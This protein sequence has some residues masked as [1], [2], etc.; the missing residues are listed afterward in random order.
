MR[1]VSAFLVFLLL[2][3]LAAAQPAAQPLRVSREF[4]AAEP[5]MGPSVLSAHTAVAGA[6]PSGFLVAWSQEDRVVATLVGP[7]G[8]PSDRT[9]DLG[10]TGAPREIVWDGT[11]WVVVAALWEPTSVGLLRLSEEGVPDP[12]GW[13]TLTTAAYRASCTAGSE[14]LL[15]TGTFGASDWRVS[16]IDAHGDELAAR[17]LGIDALPVGIGSD[18]ER[19]MVVSFF[20]GS[21]GLPRGYGTT[22]YD[23]ALEPAAGAVSILPD[24]SGTGDGAIV[25]PSGHSSWLILTE[26]LLAPTAIVVGDDGSP[27]MAPV[28][29]GRL[30][31]PRAAAWTGS[32]WLVLEARYDVENVQWAPIRIDATGSI[33]DAVTLGDPEKA[34]LPYAELVVGA[35]GIL[36]VLEN[37]GVPSA[38]MLDPSGAVRTGRAVLASSGRLVGVMSVAAGNEVSAFAWSQCDAAGTNPGVY[39]ARVTASGQRLDGEGIRIASTPDCSSQPRIASSGDRFLLVWREP[40]SGVVSLV[41]RRVGADGTMLDSAPFEIASSWYQWTVASDGEDFLVVYTGADRQLYATA[42]DA[43]GIVLNPA[44]TRVSFTPTVAPPYL[45]TSHVEPAAV[46]DGSDYLIVWDERIM[47]PYPPCYGCPLRRL[48]G[49]WAARLSPSLVLRDPAGVP[50]AGSCEECFFATPTVASAGETVAIAW[51]GD[52]HVVATVVHA[53]LRDRSLEPL[54]RTTF[55]GMSPSVAA[56]A[57]RFFLATID[58]SE[59]LSVREL[60]ATGELAIVGEPFSASHETR[61]GLAGTKRAG[62]VGYARKDAEAGGSRSLFGRFVWPE[63]RSRLVR[64]TGEIGHHQR[65]TARGD[66]GE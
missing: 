55:P 24:P 46:F 66:A 10:A 40:R 1:P 48:D 50:I 17:D 22:V 38:A 62:I 35:E 16:R 31:A 49:I 34:I 18:G 9:I 39:V 53:E 44:G 63:V 30:N 12:A 3:L 60:F 4:R 57:G 41:G 5:R 61:F 65:K 43:D 51:A 11:A 56:A 2:P 15:V 42:V 45:E 36:A 25:A 13:R 52:T 58:T 23:R 64:R 7:G 54:V 20:Y 37:S 27:L 8:E 47:P 29:L 26:G 21:G 32:E 14:I 33:R 59:M 28:A 19:T 6:G